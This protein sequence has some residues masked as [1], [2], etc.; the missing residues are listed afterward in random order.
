MTLTASKVSFR[1]GDLMK[2]SRPGH[3]ISELTFKAYAP[4]RRLCVVTALKVYIERTGPTRGLNTQLFLTTRLP[5][6]PATRDTLRR[7]T[8]TVLNDAGIDLD[9]FKP[10]STRSA[11]SSKAALTVPLTTIMNTVGWSCS[12]VFAKYYNKPVMKQDAFASAVLS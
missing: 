9:I 6:K 4:D 2:T 3:H 12:S 8:K 1:I 10:H 5:V 7:W 11:A